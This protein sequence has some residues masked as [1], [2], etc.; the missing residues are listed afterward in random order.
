MVEL[1]GEERGGIKIGWKMEGEKEKEM[2]NRV[3]ELER[4]LEKKE[5]EDSKRNI[6]IKGLEVKKGKE[7]RRLRNFRKNRS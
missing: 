4:R 7:G 1:E 3:K 5:R 6:I 2:V